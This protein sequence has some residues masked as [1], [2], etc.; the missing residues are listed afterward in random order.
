MPLL[1]LPLN[2]CAESSSTK[3]V[4]S[5]VIPCNK[6]F[7]LLDKN[8]DRKNSLNK[9]LRKALAQ[10]PRRYTV[11]QTDSVALLITVDAF[12]SA[13]GRYQLCSSTKRIAAFS[14][15]ADFLWSISLISALDDLAAPTY[16]VK[17]F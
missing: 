5:I 13:S 8:E 16:S 17:R 15:V 10:M 7:R 4:K 11:S 6:H 2:R 14:Y 1:G 3:F 9:N 12:M